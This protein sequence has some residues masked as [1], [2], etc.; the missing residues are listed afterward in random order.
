MVTSRD[1]ISCVEVA[2]WR[3]GTRSDRLAVRSVEKWKARS[4]HAVHSGELER[5]TAEGN[6]HVVVV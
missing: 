2:P 3:R 6:E 1:W 5:G 4:V